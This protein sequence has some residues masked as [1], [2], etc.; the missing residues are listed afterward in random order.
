MGLAWH[1]TLR[2]CTPM[3]LRL[4][5]SKAIRILAITYE[6][7]LKMVDL[8]VSVLLANGP[9]RCNDTIEIEPMVSLRQMAILRRVN[10]EHIGVIKR[11]IE[12][13]LT[14]VAHRPP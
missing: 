10:D 4:T 5:V 3:Q 11:N 7:A 8:D 12:T 9:T 1:G 13:I 2:T 6:Y 14:H